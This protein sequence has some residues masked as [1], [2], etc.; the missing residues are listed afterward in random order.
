MRHINQIG[1]FWQVEIRA[2]TKPVQFS[3][4]PGLSLNGVQKMITIAQT[5][6]TAK[7]ANS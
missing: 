7:S 2:M 6:I 5:L 3:N 4:E 1:I